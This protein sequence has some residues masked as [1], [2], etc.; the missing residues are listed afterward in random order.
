MIDDRFY[1]EPPDNENAAVF[2]CENCGISIF[3]GDK[4][5]EIDCE[6]LCE[7]CIDLIYSKFAQSPGSFEHEY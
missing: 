5:F 7:D 2:Q 3:E 6:V 4:Y 1:L